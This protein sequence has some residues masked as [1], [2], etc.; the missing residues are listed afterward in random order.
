MW[1][2]IILLFNRHFEKFDIN[3]D[4]ENKCSVNV[5]K[6]FDGNSTYDKQ[7]NTDYECG[8]SA[9]LGLNRASTNQLFITFE[10]NSLSTAKGFSIHF[11][12]LVLL[13]NTSGVIS[14]LLD[15]NGNYTNNLHFLN[16]IS[17]P[18]N[19]YI[20]FSFPIFA[21]QDSLLCLQD[22]VNVF[23]GST[24]ADDPLFKGCRDM[25]LGF[26]AISDNSTVLVEFI[27]GKFFN[28]YNY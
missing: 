6:V 25:G 21:V 11:E 26:T 19:M 24:D 9:P 28:Y 16:I 3:K 12:C 20:N 13:T 27:T 14:N 15:I 4:I 5:V 2:I 18:L 10:S 22:V 23:D 7:L 1:C 17:C 8:H